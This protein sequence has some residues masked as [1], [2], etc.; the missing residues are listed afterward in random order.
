MSPLFL[1]TAGVSLIGFLIS[2][3]IHRTKSKN[4]VLVCPLEGSCDAVVQSRY[5]KFLG[6]PVELLGMGYYAITWIL[7]ATIFFGVIPYSPMVSLVSVA[8]AVAGGFFSL[9]LISIQAFTLRQWCTWCV[10]SAFL[11]IAIALFS[12][13]VSAFGFIE[14]L[15]E[16]KSTVVILHAL[17][18]SLGVGGAIITDIFFFKFLKDGRID[19]EED[20]TLK[21]FSQI[22]WIALAGLV[23]TGLALFFTDVSTYSSSS[24]FITKV[25][26]VLVIGFNGAVLNLIIT[27]Q[28]QDIVF[29]GKKAQTQGRFGR[30]RRLAFASGAIS[31]SSWL[32]VF[33]LGSLRSIPYTVQ[34]GVLGYGALL[35][36]FVA[37]S[38]IYAHLLSKKA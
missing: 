10:V 30:L 26:A 17:T 9:Y 5:S 7:Y 20:E 38:Q 33:I 29:G 12:V 3:Y 18:A 37:G 8:L 28:M 23:I 15:T 11:S 13:A 21:T 32:L 1:I 6:A 27:P 19:D 36:F 16:Y 24:K 4:E 14:A 35:I 25:I 31:I 2:W 34:E 22:M